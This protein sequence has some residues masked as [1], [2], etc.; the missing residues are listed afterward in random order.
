MFRLILIALVSLVMVSCVS[1]QTPDA[2]TLEVIRR[3][4]TWTGIM[5]DKSPVYARGEESE[6]K[7]DCSGAIWYI[8][9]RSGLPYP[10]TTAYKMFYVWSGLVIE[11]KSKRQFPFLQWFDF[12][13][14]FDHVSI[15]RYRDKRGT[16]YAHASWSRQKFVRSYMKDNST[17]DKAVSGVKEIYLIPPNR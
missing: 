11:D 16:W 15:V 7:A 9:H 12:K 10:R 17:Q 2:E 4:D 1:A 6:L 13:K 14:P 8:F 5:E 3:L